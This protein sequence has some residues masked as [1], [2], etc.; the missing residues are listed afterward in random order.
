MDLLARLQHEKQMAMVLITHDLG[1][2]AQNSR[3]VAVMYAGQMVETSTVPE[4]FEQP[5]HPYTEALLQ[6]IPELAIGQKRLN[7]LPG[8]VP[9]QY[10]RPKGCLSSPRCPYKQPECEV[11]PPILLTENGK[12]RCIKTDF[13]ARI[14]S[15]TTSTSN[16]EHLG[17][18]L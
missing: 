17:S 16:V 13:P 9:S 5:A 1:L 14:T 11:P 7:S 8:V 10:D 2:V 6:A 4:I 12:V 3:D 18:T 15:N